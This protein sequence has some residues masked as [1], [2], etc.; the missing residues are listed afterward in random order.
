[1]AFKLS[2]DDCTEHSLVPD[3]PTDA[4]LQELCDSFEKAKAVPNEFKELLAK[5]HEIP[6]LKDED[7]HDEEVAG[8]VL[9]VKATIDTTFVHARSYV[10]KCHELADYICDEEQYTIKAIEEGN[11]EEFKDFLEEVLSKSKCCQKDLCTL[12]DFINA[13]KESISERQSMIEEK[14]D[15]AHNKCTDALITSAVAGTG[16]L[17]G[18]VTTASGVTAIAGGVGYLP[19]LVG[20]VIVTM[21]TPQALVL[22]GVIAVPIGL[23]VALAGLVVAVRG[24]KNYNESKKVEE[25][26]MK[27]LVA[28]YKM[29]NKL[30]QIETSLKNVNEHLK[31][32]I[33]N[34]LNDVYEDDERLEKLKP[35]KGRSGSGQVKRS[36]LKKLKTVTKET[37]VLKE[38][39]HPLVNA[40]SLEAFI[41]LLEM[42]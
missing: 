1:M 14:K 13:E 10:T 35:V 19:V 39:C 5:I 40:K 18:A 37:N 26:C 20:G 11:V 27:A 22:G 25:F 29:K 33:D 3:T 23:G 41:K 12:I 15:K 24:H 16:A 2:D 42:K 31:T 9:Q 6:Q 32:A 17:I 28:V 36:I 21:V 4:A 7:I 30:I 34:N 38:Y 8:A